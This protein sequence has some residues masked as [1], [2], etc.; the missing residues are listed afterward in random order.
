MKQ[1][2]FSIFDKIDPQWAQEHALEIFETMPRFQRGVTTAKFYHNYETWK[3]VRGSKHPLIKKFF[4][5]IDENEKYFE[6]IYK[7]KCNVHICRLTYVRDASKDISVWHKD[8]KYLNGNMHLT[9]KGNC[10]LLIKDENCTT[11]LQVPDGTFFFFNATEYLHTVKPTFDE[12]IEACG[13]IDESKESIDAYYASAE[14]HPYKLCDSNHP[15]WIDWKT[16]VY[17]YMKKSFADGK[18]SA[19]YPADWAQE[20]YDKS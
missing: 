18:A 7:R 11:H 3:F 1:D 2:Y 13:F 10:N 8:G 16:N 12:R 14:N 6:N 5:L 9:I 15:S 20:E 4:D 19:E 17:G